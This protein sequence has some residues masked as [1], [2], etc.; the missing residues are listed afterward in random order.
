LKLIARWLFTEVTMPNPNPIANPMHFFAGSEDHQPPP[1]D[2]EEAGQRA[3][4]NRREDLNKIADPGQRKE[5]EIALRSLAERVFAETDSHIDKVKAFQQGWYSILESLGEKNPVRR[6]GEKALRKVQDHQ[7]A[8]LGRFV[9]NEEGKEALQADAIL[10]RAKEA[11]RSIKA[12]QQKR[13]HS[14]DFERDR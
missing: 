14:R 1:R 7:D 9:R 4:E 5:A 12:R 3:I 8:R 6:V 11:A 13:D 2:K 10:A